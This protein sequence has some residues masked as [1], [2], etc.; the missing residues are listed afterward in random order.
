M[1]FD[2]FISIL[3]NFPPSAVAEAKASATISAEI[4]PF[5]ISSFSTEMF[6]PVFSAIT[7][8][9]LNPALIIC[10]KSVPIS[11]PAECICANASTSEL[12][13]WELPIEI[14]PICFNVGITFS[15]AILNP[16]M[17]CAPLARSFNPIGVSTANSL[18]SPKNF[19]ALSSLPNKTPKETSR[20][21]ISPLTLMTSF[22][23]PVNVSTA[24]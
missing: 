7:E 1:P 10:N 6:L 3:W 24:K 20:L 21:S 11:F 23:N 12:N 14:S 9:G 22:P 2:C 15:A 19:L 4:A 16:N 18:N 5:D 8:S 17:V 13:R